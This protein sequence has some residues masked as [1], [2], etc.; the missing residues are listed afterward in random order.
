MKSTDHKQQGNGIEIMLPALLASIGTGLLVSLVLML[1]VLALNAGQ[2]QAGQ[3]QSHG[4]L[5]KVSVIDQCY[6]LNRKSPP[7]AC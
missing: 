5:I 7:G 1:A 2:A 4:S 3:L 6:E